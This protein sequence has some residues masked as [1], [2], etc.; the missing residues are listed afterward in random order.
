MGTFMRELKSLSDAEEF[1]DFLDIEY[2]EHLVDVNRL[3]ILKKYQTYLEQ[4]EVDETNDD[5][6]RSAHR[7]CL[8]RAHMDFTTTDAR[9]E[10]LFK[11]FK[12]EQGKAFVGLD[13]IEPLGGEP[14]GSSAEA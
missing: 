1:F 13:A 10:K 14:V 12:E 11:V 6:L 3:H 5:A 2:D 7:A 4:T 9:T 8:A